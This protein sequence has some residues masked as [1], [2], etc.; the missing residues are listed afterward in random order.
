MQVAMLQKVAQGQVK[1]CPSD[2]LSFLD[3]STTSFLVPCLTVHQALHVGSPADSDGRS[4]PLSVPRIGWGAGGPAMNMTGSYPA[5]SHPNPTAHPPSSGPPGLLSAG[6]AL[7]ATQHGGEHSFTGG[8]WLRE[9][10]WKRGV[11][12]AHPHRQRA[13][14]V[15][16]L[17]PT[18]SALRRPHRPVG[19]RGQ[20]PGTSQRSLLTPWPPS[21][22]FTGDASGSALGNDCRA[23]PSSS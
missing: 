14:P 5:E 2:H 13:G 1:N 11:G 15:S 16:S 8:L 22:P 18:G 3:R 12:P 7:R 20:A 4:P 23:V 17:L 21:C 9:A 6:S 10:T 19:R